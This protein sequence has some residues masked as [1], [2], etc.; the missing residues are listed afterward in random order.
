VVR[1]AI[2]NARLLLVSARGRGFGDNAAAQRFTLLLSDAE[3]ALRALLALREA[4]DDAEPAE[5]PQAVLKVLADRMNAVGAA[6]SNAQ[7]APVR[8]APAALA[9]KA[10][11][12]ALRAA[13]AW[14]QAAERHLAGSAESAAPTSDAAVVQPDRRLRKLRD[15]LTTDSLSLRHA[16]RF[17][18]TGATLTMLTKGLHIEMG[19][20]ITI[21]AVIILQAYPS[22]TWQRAIPAGRRYAAWRPDCRRCRVRPAWA[23]CDRH[24][25]DSAQPAVD[26]LPRGQLRALYRL[27]HAAVHPHNGVGQSQWSAVTGAWRAANAGQ[28]GGSGVRHAGHLCAVA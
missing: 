19:Y 6:L 15:N 13:T 2:E 3:G 25:S 22:A 5:A 4:L 17:A 14:I 16:A 9:D 12:A 10:A 8:E 1:E 27:H 26:G 11:A 18:L 24:R 21:T 23:G 28:P 20:W 7:R